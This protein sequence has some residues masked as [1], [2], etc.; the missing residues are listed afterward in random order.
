ML[1]L[2]P[3]RRAVLG[4]T[5]VAVAAAV[6]GA[7]IRWE[8][9]LLF[10]GAGALW[11]TW[12]LGR[13]VD[14]LRLNVERLA[15]TSEQ[16]GTARGAGGLLEMS[17]RVRLGR[18]QLEEARRRA[19]GERDD[20]RGI[21]EA[22]TDGILVVGHGN[23]VQLIN[24]AAR[25]LLKPQVDPLEQP[26]D[27]VVESPA[28]VAFAAELR[29]GGQP[30]PQ[31]VAVGRAPDQRF[32]RLSGAVIQGTRLRQRVVLVFH[33]VTDL[34]HLQQVRTDFV[35]NVTH[36]MRSPL[37][38][39]LGYTETLAEMEDLSE[40]ERADSVARIL[41]NARRLDDIIRDL[42]EL[43]RLEHTT[44]PQ[45]EPTDLAAL[46]RDCVQAFGDLAVEKGIRITID[47][48]TGEVAFELDQG[49]V[50]QALTNLVENAVK[51]TPQ[52]GSVRVG[53]RLVEH[54]TQGRPAREAPVRTLELSVA[55]TGPGIPAEDHGRIFERFYRVDTAR[56][57][58]LGGTGLG[59]AIVKHA[60]VVHGG[61][62]HLESEVG[63]GTT[64][65][66]LLP[67]A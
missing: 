47:M 5:S 26:L 20:V 61:E 17:E 3:F 33:D 64:F 4:R 40:E 55:D 14:P 7:H 49:L 32:L 10:G 28:I 38:S 23:R 30:A 67:L 27:L 57:R 25:R 50:H 59:L 21:L 62:V 48:A 65:R 37:A 31:R 44:A 8:F 43:S 41:R 52:G 56:S 22:T 13:R 1:S 15:A 24:D 35:A 34:Q 18:T 29:E 19:E 39:I 66:L 16:K 54:I 6:M 36:E 53:A 46:V 2:D 63:R 9:G 45:T 58:A 11:V 12:S 42:I 51:Y 60:A